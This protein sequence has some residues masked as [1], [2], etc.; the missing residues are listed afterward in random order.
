MVTAKPKVTVYL[1]DKIFLRLK[2][3]A[4]RPGMSYSEIAEQALTLWYSED[5][6]HEQNNPLL[7]R[8]DRMNRA[9]EVHTRK[10]AVVSDALGLFIQYFLTLIPE[11]PSDRRETASDLGI[12][13]FNRFIEDLTT[14]RSDSTRG[15]LARAEDVMADISSFF[16]KEQLETM[17]AP[18]PE[19]SDAMSENE[20]GSND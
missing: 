17:N 9:D 20:G 7:R 14:V 10:L 1:S 19:R 2:L 11:I 12:L 18:A 3:D 4:S 6:V 15:I 8:M 5:R 16:T 13:R